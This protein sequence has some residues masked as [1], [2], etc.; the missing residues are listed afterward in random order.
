MPLS[1]CKATNKQIDSYSTWFQNVD[2]F[3]WC[4]VCVRCTRTIDSVCITIDF[5]HLVT[6]LCQCT[7]STSLSTKVSYRVYPL[8]FILFLCLFLSLWP[9][10]LHIS[11]RKS[12][13]AL[14]PQW[15][16][17]DAEIEVLPDENT[18]LK[19][20]L[21]KAW[22]RSVFCHA[23]YAYRQGFLPC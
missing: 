22:S 3:K 19:G 4:F 14:T 1:N 13:S 11:L 17:A 9:F 20:S 8:L 6:I 21:F 5:C 18:D 2:S 12:P 23:C 16:A 10:Q 7:H 15:R